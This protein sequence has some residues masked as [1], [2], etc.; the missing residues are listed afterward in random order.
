MCVSEERS[1]LLMWAHYAKDH[2]GAVFEFLSLPD[3]GNPLLV[4]EPVMYVDHPIPFFT[5]SE[6]LDH[7]FSVRRLNESELYKRYVYTKSSDW[8]YEREW[9]CYPFIRRRTPCTKMFLFVR[10]NL[11][12]CTSGVE[13]TRTSLMK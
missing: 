12:L 9:R 13:L 6:W 8:R 10:Q 5:E 1:N 11:Q 2:T 4:A 3:E 7:I